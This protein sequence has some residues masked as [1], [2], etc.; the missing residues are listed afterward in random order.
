MENKTLKVSFFFELLLLKRL[1]IFPFVSRI[2]VQ[3][4]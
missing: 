2:E 1:R 3:E 4:V